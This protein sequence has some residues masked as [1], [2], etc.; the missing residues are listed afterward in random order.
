MEIL[1]PTDPLNSTRL[2]PGYAPSE[3]LTQLMTASPLQ[4]PLMAW[5]VTITL[6]FS[7]EHPLPFT[8]KIR[9]PSVTKSNKFPDI[10]LTTEAWLTGHS[11]T[12]VFIGGLLPPPS[13]R[14]KYW[15]RWFPGLSKATPHIFLPP[16][17]ADRFHSRRCLASHSTARAFKQ[18]RKKA[19]ISKI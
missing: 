5:K 18:H 3:P 4:N 10:I 7:P 8:H 15:I 14:T 12:S 11:S 2:V 16:A 9:K 13:Q 17:P 19:T 1:S 6:Y